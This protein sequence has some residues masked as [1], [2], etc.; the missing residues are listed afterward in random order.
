MTLLTPLS[1][2]NASLGTTPDTNAWHY[3]AVALGFVLLL[4]GAVFLMCSAFMATGIIDGESQH[5]PE[6]AGLLRAL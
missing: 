5:R 4:I 6:R 2:S 3:S 1:A